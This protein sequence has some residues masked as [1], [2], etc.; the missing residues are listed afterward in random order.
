MSSSEAAASG[1]VIRTRKHYDPEG[2]RR[3]LRYPEVPEPLEVGTYDNHTHLEIADGD[4]PLTVAEQLDLAKRA[5]MLGAVQVGVTL[6]SSIWSAQVAEHEPMLL[7]AV[8]IHPNEAP[9]YESRAQLDEA[10]SKIA[11]S[12]LSF[13][14]TVLARANEVIWEI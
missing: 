13:S 7:A 2:H 3:D 6:D 12:S 1:E 10:I 14:S 5:G 4:N 9:R 8:A 11:L